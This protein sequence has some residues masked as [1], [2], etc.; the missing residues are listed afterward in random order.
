MS[1][2]LSVHVEG[3]TCQS[4]VKAITGVVTALN[5]VFSC[6]VS[7]EKKSADVSFDASLVTPT[8]IKQTIEDAGFF[9]FDKDV[10]SSPAP[11]GSSSEGTLGIVGMTCNS[12]VKSIEDRISKIHGVKS[13]KVTLTTASA[14]VVYSPNDVS[15]ETVR[16]A[17]DEMGFEASLPSSHV[18]SGACVIQSIANPVAPA[19][20][21]HKSVDKMLNGAPFKKIEDMAD[22]TI[23]DKLSLH[24]KGKFLLPILYQILS[25]IC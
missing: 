17:I 2:E 4:C 23:A 19:M 22:P 3:M 13:I 6:V 24:V 14:R 5:G 11:S 7:L 18:V 1:T 12:C 9:V 21:H 16:A 15:L 8:L 20:S 25:C 10:A